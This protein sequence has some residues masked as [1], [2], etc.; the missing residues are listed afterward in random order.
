M[1]LLARAEGAQGLFESLAAKE[2]ASPRLF[3]PA[4]GVGGNLLKGPRWSQHLAIENAERLRPLKQLRG[5]E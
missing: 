5:S 3:P 1:L 2:V 4:A